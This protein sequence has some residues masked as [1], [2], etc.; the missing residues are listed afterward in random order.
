MRRN[1]LSAAPV[2]SVLVLDVT[3]IAG[4]AARID[5]FKRELQAEMQNKGMCHLNSPLLHSCLPGCDIV[6]MIST[7]SK[8]GN[9]TEY[10][11]YIACRR[12]R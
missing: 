2:G 8:V 3:G 7:F 10:A 11:D 9:N 6:G 12:S 1:F 5:Q 4:A